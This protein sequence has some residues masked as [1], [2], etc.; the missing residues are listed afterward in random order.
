MNIVTKAII[1]FLGISFTAA[2]SAGPNGHYR[3]TDKDGTIKYADRPPEGVEAEFIKFANHKTYKS[4]KTGEQGGEEAQTEAEKKLHAK[5]EVVPKKDPKLCKQAKDNLQAL[6]GA[7]IRITEDDG[8][9]R[10]LT[11]DEKEYQRDNAKKFIKI[12][13]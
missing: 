2:L 10:Y 13:C 9:K 7:R 12:N 8:S 6:K 3:W 4:A 5:M 1:I 11:E